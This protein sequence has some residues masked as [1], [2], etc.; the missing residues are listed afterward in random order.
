MIGVLAGCVLIAGTW[1]ALGRRDASGAA[2]RD[3]EPPRSIAVLPFLNIGGD[4]TGDYFSDGV[5]EEILHAL[6]QLPDLR[7]AA[8]TSAF[9]FKGKA[10]DVRDIG[11]PIRCGGGVG[12]EV[13]SA[14]ARRFGLRCS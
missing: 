3:V 5:T 1:F 8:R 14:K 9:R 6:T 12:G 2:G 10:V 7:V 11:A 4:S 13:S